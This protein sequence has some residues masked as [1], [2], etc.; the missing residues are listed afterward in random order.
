MNCR[1]AK[2]AE[3]LAAYNLK[4]VYKLEAENPANAS[5]RRLEFK[6]AGEIKVTNLSLVQVLL[7]D[8]ECIKRKQGLDR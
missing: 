6:E 2:W 4:I 3:Y 5:L 8:K 1:Q 7:V